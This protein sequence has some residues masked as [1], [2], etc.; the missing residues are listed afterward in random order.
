MMDDI[1][2]DNLY[3]P[4]IIHVVSYCEALFLA[5]PDILNDSIKITREALR[6]YRKLKKSGLA[7]NV[8]TDDTYSRT[9]ELEKAAK[10]IIRAMEENIPNLY[11]PEGFYIAFVAGWL[12]VQNYGLILRNFYMQKDWE[13]QISNGNYSFSRRWNSITD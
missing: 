2:S 13:T 3:S 12:P 4:E 1:D 10:G 11:S 7:P 9:L 8:K 6:R 5:T